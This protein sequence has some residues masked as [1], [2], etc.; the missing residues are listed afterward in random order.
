MLENII[1]RPVE[2][3]FDL[4]NSTIPHDFKRRFSLAFNP[5]NYIK[6]VGKLDKEIIKDENN[7]LIYSTRFYDIKYN[8]EDCTIKLFGKGAIFSLG[9]QDLERIFTLIKP[10]EIY[11]SQTL[12][13]DQILANTVAFE[14]IEYLLKDCGILYDIIPNGTYC[15]KPRERS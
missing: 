4:N 2:I 14:R 7:T 12:I 1:S 10:V 8:Y 13:M 11:N 15:I 5:A 9:R 6:F 3:N